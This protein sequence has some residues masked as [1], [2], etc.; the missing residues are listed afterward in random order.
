MYV[1]I[2]FELQNITISL[3]INFFNKKA[4]SFSQKELCQFIVIV[5]WQINEFFI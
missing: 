1:L 3:Y 4:S 5:K 2:N